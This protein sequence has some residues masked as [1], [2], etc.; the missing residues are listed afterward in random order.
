M[1]RYL[2]PIL[3]LLSLTACDGGGRKAVITPNGVGNVTFD[4]A[5]PDMGKGFT[6]ESD[7]LYYDGQEG[8]PYYIV[9]NRKGEVVLNVF[10]GVSIEAYSPDYET[11]A[12]IHPGMSLSEAVAIAGE[13]NLNVWYNWPDNYFIIDDHSEGFSW[14]VYGDQ[15][16]GGREA[17]ERFRET[18]SPD[19]RLNHFSP[20]AVVAW[21][22]VENRNPE[23]ADEESSVE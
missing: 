19:I 1:L 15:L 7:T 16:Q 12:G 18:G 10:P 5:V 6:A 17:F 21:I 11:E 22:T 2:T 3:L 9:K 13:A 23:T 14:Q 4:Q 20:D 8:E